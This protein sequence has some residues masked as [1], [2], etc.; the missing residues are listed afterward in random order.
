MIMPSKDVTNLEVRLCLLEEGN[1][2]EEATAD[3]RKFF[4]EVSGL[5]YK[6]STTCIMFTALF[7]M[8]IYIF[9]INRKNVC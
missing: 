8:C 3:F 6:N 1:D 7:Y 2:Q 5:L 4:Y 9:H